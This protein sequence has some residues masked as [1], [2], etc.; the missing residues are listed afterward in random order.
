M[1]H[2]LPPLL[3]DDSLGRLNRLDARPESL[4]D[5]L[6]DKEAAKR[7]PRLPFR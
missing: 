2:P 7:N 1:S 4:P 5:Y 3:R 6:L